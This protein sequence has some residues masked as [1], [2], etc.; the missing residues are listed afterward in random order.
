MQINKIREIQVS[1]HGREVGR[2]RK[3]SGK[4]VFEYSE[5]WLRGGF[6][7]SPLD[8][9]LE[10]RLFSAP[11]N[12]P[13]GNFGVFNDSL[14][15]GYG[16]YLIDRMLRHDGGSILDLDQMQLMSIVGSSGMGALEYSPVTDIVGREDKTDSKDFDLL[17]KKALDVLSEADDSD[18]SLLYY[19]SGNSGGARPKKLYTDAAGRHW[20]VK[21]RHLSDPVDIGA[22]EQRYALAARDCGIVVPETKLMADKYFASE[23]FDI[24]SDGTRLHTVTAAGILGVDFRA[25]TADYT[26]LLALTGY[27]TQ[28][29]AQVE[30][31]FR[32]MVFN[33]ISLNKDDHAKNFSFIYRESSGEGSAA[34]A[35]SAPA[36]AFVRPGWQLAPAYDLTYSPEGTRGEH[37]T[38]VFFNGNPGL[39]DVLRAG[40][41]IRIP[42]KR[43]LEIVEEIQSVCASRLSHIQA[44]I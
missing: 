27:L 3:T 24:A 5:Q 17:Q 7:I 30:Q 41:G 31:M 9:P 20:L 1:Y 18:A 29:P 2:I 16:L 34:P 37:S 8:L 25:Q 40:T 28:D 33:I 15:D 36:P 6:S 11:D 21:F 14:P 23:R 35:G 42:R 43:C 38:S 26:N 10:S 13:A 12:G 44:L 19:N 4:C 39:E 22:I 32:L